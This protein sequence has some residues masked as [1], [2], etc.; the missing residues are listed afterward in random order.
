MQ[1]SNNNVLTILQYDNR[2]ECIEFDYFN[3]KLVLLFFIINHSLPRGED[4]QDVVNDQ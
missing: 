1:F 4:D 3:I 2:F